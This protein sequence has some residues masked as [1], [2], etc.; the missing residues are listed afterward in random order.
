MCGSLYEIT[1]VRVFVVLRE[2][3]SLKIV[4]YIL[5]IANCGTSIP[6]E[7]PYLFAHT[8]LSIFFQVF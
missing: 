3:V 4:S 7:M 6:V 1:V 2:D 5:S 8:F